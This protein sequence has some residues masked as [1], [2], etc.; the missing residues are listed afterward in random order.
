MVS[1]IASHCIPSSTEVVSARAVLSIRMRVLSTV[2][3][4]LGLSV[5]GMVMY[6][7]CAVPAI[8]TQLMLWIISA[9][10]TLVTLICSCVQY[11]LLRRYEQQLLSR[12]VT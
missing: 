2:I 11:Y 12:N 10:V 1:F 5:I 7:F 4:L 9:S 3:A 6:G 8:A